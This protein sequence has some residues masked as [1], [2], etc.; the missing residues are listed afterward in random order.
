MKLPLN[1]KKNV[2]SSLNFM[3]D[4]YHLGKLKKNSYCLQPTSFGWIP[5]IFIIKFLKGILMY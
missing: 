1:Q 5:G 4:Y 3:L 2:V